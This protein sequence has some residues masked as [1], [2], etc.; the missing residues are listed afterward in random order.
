MEAILFPTVKRGRPKQ[1]NENGDWEQRNRKDY[2]KNY[3]LSHSQQVN[4][5]CCKISINKY[6]MDK[7]KKSL[8]HIREYLKKYE[9]NDTS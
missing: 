8:S 6:S 5:E 3:Y 1:I 7:H 9:T 4:C 2:N